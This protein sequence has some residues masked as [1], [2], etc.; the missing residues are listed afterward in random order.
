MTTSGWHRINPNTPAAKARRAKYN[1]PEHRAARKHYAAW[2]ATGNGRCWR[3]GGRIEP[4][5]DW[6][7]GHDDDDVNVIRGAEHASC[8]KRAA[9]VKGNRI[10]NA[11]RAIAKTTRLTW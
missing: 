1:S 4:G 5:S 9:A 10:A 6:H 11:R 8:N 2:I 7:V 3:C